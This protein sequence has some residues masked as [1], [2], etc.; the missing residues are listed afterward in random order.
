MN[1]YDYEEL[2]EFYFLYSQHLPFFGS[3]DLDIEANKRRLKDFFAKKIIVG[4]AL[5][6]IGALIVFHGFHN[7]VTGIFDAEQRSIPL[8]VLYLIVIAGLICAY[9]GLRTASRSCDYLICRRLYERVRAEETLSILGDW[10]KTDRV[11]TI[12]SKLS[13]ERS[14][15]T[16]AEMINLLMTIEYEENQAAKQ[17]IRSFA[18]Q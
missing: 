17:T 9:V 15:L 6:C 18:E 13:T 1:G 14:E 5:I 7:L 2:K 12:L 16:I 4:L 3:R 8:V 10:T 11:K